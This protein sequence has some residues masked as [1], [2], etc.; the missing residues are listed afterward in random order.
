MFIVFHDF[1]FSFFFLQKLLRIPRFFMLLNRI[2]DNGTSFVLVE[3]RPITNAE[4]H[5]FGL[6]K[7]SHRTCSSRWF[8]NVLKVKKIKK[9]RERFRKN[10][11]TRNGISVANNADTF[12]TCLTTTRHLFK[13]RL[14][15]LRLSV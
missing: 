15:L 5:I 2:R 13:F 6:G 8:K 3:I 1:F 7:N 10:K 14:K 9:L 11:K 12:L 4:K